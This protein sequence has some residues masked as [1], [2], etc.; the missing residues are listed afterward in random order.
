[1]ASR[2]R[3]RWMPACE[4]VSDCPAPAAVLLG[5]AAVLTCLDH[6]AEALSGGAPGRPRPATDGHSGD[7]AGRMDAGSRTGRPRCV[8]AD[9]EFSAGRG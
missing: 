9:D 2:R 6:Y 4:W 8:A 5:P 1:M 7:A 3:A